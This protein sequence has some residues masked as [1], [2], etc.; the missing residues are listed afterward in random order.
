[1]L[2]RVPWHTMILC[3]KVNTGATVGQAF[4]ENCV[5][6]C[7]RGTSAPCRCGAPPCPCACAPPCRCGA[8]LPKHLPTLSRNLP[9][10][11][12]ALGHSQAFS[13][14]SRGLS[15]AKC[16]QIQ[17]KRV[18]KDPWM[19]KD[20]YMFDLM[21][22]GLP[23]INSCQQ[24]QH[25]GQNVSLLFALQFSSLQTLSVRLRSRKGTES[26]L[27]ISPPKAMRDSGLLETSGNRWPSL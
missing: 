18:G 23:R 10:S 27:S 3:P 22:R 4:E 12:L 16:N 26:G 9:P 19:L 14:N 17:S 11:P 13:Q 7:F 6:W 20:N 5:C 15:L 24:K 1:M 8:P 25:L 2:S 21:W